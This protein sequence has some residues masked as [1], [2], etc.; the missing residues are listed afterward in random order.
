MTDATLPAPTARSE[1]MLGIALVFAATVGWSFSGVFTRLLTTDIW[2]AIAWR[3][4]FGGLFLLIPYVAISGPGGFSQYN[5]DDAPNN[6]R[7]SR[8]VVTLPA[9]GEYTIHATSYAGGETGAYQLNI[10]PAQ[11]TTAADVLQGGP[12]QTFAQCPPEGVCEED[13]RWATGAE[14]PGS[15]EEHGDADSQQDPLRIKRD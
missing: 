14:L 12:G 11:S 5:D 15:A 1:H 6:T 8:L 7:N 13:R 2:T 9:T 4:F 3:S 10:G